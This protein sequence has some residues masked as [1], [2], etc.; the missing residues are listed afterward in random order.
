MT[1][2]QRRLFLIGTS[3]GILALALGLVLSALQEKI[4]FFK[5][6][7]EVAEKPVEI[8]KRFRIGGL[9]KPG[10][11]A[12]GDDLLVRFEITDGNQNVP[13]AYRG[14]VPDLFR[15]GQGVVAEGALD[16]SHVFNA[17][18][19][20]AKHDERYMPKEVADALK[21]QGHWVDSEKRM[22]PTTPAALQ[23]G[24]PK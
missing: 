15:E 4:V 5:S 13:V 21:K 7:T 9:V 12:R 1:R 2:R 6:P 22:E 3:L 17:D 24:L 20:L 8:G 18:T 23:Q 14:L 10:S 19:V 11:L 16:G